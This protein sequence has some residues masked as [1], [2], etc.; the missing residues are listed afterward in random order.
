MEADSLVLNEYQIWFLNSPS[1][2][3]TL[4]VGIDFE[5]DSVYVITDSNLAALYPIPHHM[6]SFI[7]DPPGEQNKHISIFNEVVEHMISLGLDWKVKVVAFGKFIW[8]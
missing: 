6:H 7:L 8:K 4:K 3:E 1:L 5:K 2:L